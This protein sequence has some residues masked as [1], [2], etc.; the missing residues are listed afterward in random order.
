MGT[1]AH[2]FAFAFDNR[3]DRVPLVG[4]T[5]H[6]SP[7]HGPRERP[8]VRRQGLRLNGLRSGGVVP[9]TIPPHCW[10]MQPPGGGGGG[11]NR[12]SLWGTRDK[13]DA[14]KWTQIYAFWRRVRVEEG[15]DWGFLS[16]WERT[17]HT[18][19][20]RTQ[21]THADTCTIFFKKFEQRKLRLPK[22]P[23]F[24][25]TATITKTPCEGD[26]FVDPFCAHSALSC[27]PP[28]RQPPNHIL[29]PCAVLIEGDV[30][31]QNV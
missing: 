21:Y 25:L 11:L 6:I 12:R 14:K 20:T 28:W 2:T 23:C 17:A 29:S 10:E 22:M 9:V 26:I 16:C 30:H 13:C 3:L 19:S 5:R 4:T 24:T 18:Y 27:N 8:T 31:F 7:K 15:K 1:T